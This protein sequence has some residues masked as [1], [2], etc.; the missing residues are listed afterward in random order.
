MTEGTRLLWVVL[1]WESGLWLSK[2]DGKEAVYKSEGEPVCSISPGGSAA[3]AAVL[4]SML[5]LSSCLSFSP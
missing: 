2:K 3:I 1:S 5:C 4:E